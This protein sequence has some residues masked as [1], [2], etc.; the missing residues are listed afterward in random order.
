MPLNVYFKQT[1]LTYLSVLITEKALFIRKR[2][3]FN[4]SLSLP[5][6]QSLFTEWWPD[7]QL[8]A[9][10]GTISILSSQLEFLMMNELM[11]LRLTQFS[12]FNSVYVIVVV[13][14]YQVIKLPNIVNTKYCKYQRIKQ[15]TNET[16]N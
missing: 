12:Q 5:L 15:P 6:L 11:K 3:F 13:C 4:L 16:T 9:V 10:I 14:D 7:N 2:H 1:E 8:G